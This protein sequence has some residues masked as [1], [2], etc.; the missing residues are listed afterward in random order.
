MALESCVF[1]VFVIIF[2]GMSTFEAQVV[3]FG[4]P[5]YV[6]HNVSINVNHSVFSVDDEFLSVA[7]D[8]G[9]MR[10]HW[11]PLNF[12]SA[13]FFTLAKGLSPAYLR[14]GGTSEDFLIYIGSL[15]AVDLH[16]Y[17]NETNFT[18]THADLEKIHEISSKTGW[19]IMFGLN[20]LLREKDGTWN[21]S[22]AKEIMQYIA[23]HNYQFGWELGNGES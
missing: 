5:M 9:I 8:T 21:A 16:K 2:C 7:I 23:D 1:V 17:K 11:Q 13:R 20:V 18:I 22:N 14:I 10:R 12:S 4:R 19:N 3:N 6:M 15:T